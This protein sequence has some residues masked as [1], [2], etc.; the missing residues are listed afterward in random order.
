MFW[1]TI[2][3]VALFMLPWFIRRRIL[4]W[5]FGYKIDRTAFIGRSI[6]LC[7][8]LTMGPYSYIG[9]LNVIRGGVEEVTLESYAIIGGLNW[10]SAHALSGEL[11]QKEGSVRSS[12]LTLEQHSAVTN[13]HLL[14]CSD[15]IRICAFATI[16]GWHSQIIT[17]GL[18]IRVNRQATGPIT[19]GRYCLVAT[20][21]IILKETSL[22]DYSVL[23][24]GSVLAHKMT[25]TYSLY[26]GVPAIR[27][28]ALDPKTAYF[29]RE[30]GYVI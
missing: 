12:G 3:N 2:F 27:V 7:R 17:R 14:E 18:D 13:R 16:G 1:R 11:S 21:S 5:S 29:L 8:R 30:S 23:A 20:R 26:S 22:P 10:I 6:V 24:A 4:I 28:R 19:I 15:R 25:E 9:D